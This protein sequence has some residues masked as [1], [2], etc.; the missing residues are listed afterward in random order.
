MDRF[1][2]NL[3]IHTLFSDGS[4][5]PEDVITISREADLKVIAVTDH[6]FLSDYFI[7]TV[8]YPEQDRHPTYVVFNES[9]DSW[10]FFESKD[11]F[12]NSSIE[13]YIEV[14]R[15]L[16]A[17]SV[18]PAILVGGEVS[19]PAN[20]LMLEE[21]L[22]WINNLDLVLFEDVKE[23]QLDEFI[24]ARMQMKCPVGLAHTDFSSAFVKMDLE[25]L[26]KQLVDADI[27]IELNTANALRATF[28]YSYRE[29]FE[30]GRDLGLKIS[31]G[32]DAHSR[33][34]DIVRLEDGESFVRE[35]GLE[36]NLEWIYKLARID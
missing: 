9:P 20:R 1:G 34:A 29:F 33:P 16:K 13:R 5:S 11:I 26:V 24:E 6:C 3:H 19:F 31:I 21:Q 2:I 18:K 10:E 30:I 8:I 14:L 12:K 4:F 17:G 28:F 32:S 36:K 25:T 7:N 23:T 15:A 35:L 22:E 27:F